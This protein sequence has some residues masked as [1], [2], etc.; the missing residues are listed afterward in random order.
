MKG[1]VEQI[2]ATGRANG[3]LAQPLAGGGG[4]VPARH[5]P[6][7]LISRICNLGVWELRRKRD[8]RTSEISNLQRKEVGEPAGGP[9][10]S[11]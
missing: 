7:Q 3:T 4:G 2:A 10:G 9:E 1:Q 8:S 11:T 5:L 6:P